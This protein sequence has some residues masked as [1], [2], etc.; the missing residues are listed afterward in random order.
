[1]RNPNHGHLRTRYQASCSDFFANV[2][3]PSSDD[4]EHG[5]HEEARFSDPHEL[6][7]CLRWA[8]AHVV[9][10]VGGQEVCGLLLW[11]SHYLDFRASG[12]WSVKLYIFLDNYPN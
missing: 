9:R 6:G 4:A 1:M 12:S 11:E 2:R 3:Q 5:W 8:L 10:I 7:T